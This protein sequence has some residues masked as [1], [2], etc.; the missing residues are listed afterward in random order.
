METDQLAKRAAG[1]ARRQFSLDRAKRSPGFRPCA[2]LLCAKQRKEQVAVVG[3]LCQVCRAAVL[4]M[5]HAAQL[6]GRLLQMGLALLLSIILDTAQVRVP[7]SFSAQ[8]AICNC[9]G[10]GGR[11]AVGSFR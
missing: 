2:L 6:A 1:D 5:L 11:H 10:W 8:R 3:L 4:T 9:K 7:A